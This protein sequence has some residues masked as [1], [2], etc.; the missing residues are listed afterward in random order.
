M[1]L[2][3]YEN[4][5][6]SAGLALVLDILLPGVGSI[7]AD[8]AVG[9]AITWGGMIGGIIL[10]GV[11][12]HQDVQSLD[13]NGNSMTSNS[14]DGLIIAGVVALLGFRIY[15]IVDAYQ[16]ANE[17]NVNLARKLRLPMMSLSDVSVAPIRTPQGTTLAP[18]LTW[19]F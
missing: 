19:H 8:H 16:S 9:A 6:K 11:G 10:I 14:G 3:A 15:G 4:E 17:Y 7:Y 5:K 18:T 2:M 12:V 13:A 1:Q